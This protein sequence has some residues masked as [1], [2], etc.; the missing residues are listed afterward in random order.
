MVTQKNT[1]AQAG[2]E[3][4]TATKDMRCGIVVADWHPE[5]TGGLLRGAIQTLYAAGIPKKN[6]HVHHV[7]GSFELP[8]GAHLLAQQGHVDAVICLGCIIQGETPHF[9]YICQGVTQG[10]TELNLIHN[11]PFIFG[12]LTTLTLKQAKERAGGKLGNKG[13]DAALAAIQMIALQKNLRRE[14]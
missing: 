7:P 1:R 5:I 8:M 13:E 10:I 3:R 2:K 6:I 4:A 11:L 14:K 12:V 9:T